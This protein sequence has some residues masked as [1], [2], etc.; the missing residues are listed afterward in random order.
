MGAE[1][2]DRKRAECVRIGLS[3]EP[4]GLAHGAGSPFWLLWVCSPLPFSIASTP[5]RR[6]Q[7][8]AFRPSAGSFLR[9]A[10]FSPSLSAADSWPC[11][12]I[13]VAKARTSDRTCGSSA[14]TGDKEGV[15]KFLFD[16]SVHE[17]PAVDRNDAA[18]GSRE[19]GVSRSCIPLHRTSKARVDIGFTCR[20]ETEFERRAG[21]D[22]FLD[23][24]FRQVLVG[25]GV[26]MRAARYCDEPV[27]RG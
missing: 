25:P 18:S 7:T 19:N 9:S 3:I 4:R 26:A 23:R 2:G 17:R 15:C 22:E 12:S 14:T 20:D 11:F 6:C 16:L 21:A 10:W 1:I 24:E 27:S 13:R 5:G 8:S